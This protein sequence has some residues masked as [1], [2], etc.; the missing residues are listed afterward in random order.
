MPETFG[1][2]LVVWT[3]W[4]NYSLGKKK[5]ATPTRHPGYLIFPEYKCITRLQFQKS[6]EP[7]SMKYVFPP[8]TKGNRWEIQTHNMFGA[9]L[10]TETGPW[11]IITR[12]HRSRNQSKARLIRKKVRDEYFITYI[13]HCSEQSEHFWWSYFY[14]EAKFWANDCYNTLACFRLWWVRWSLIVECMAVGTEYCCK[15]ET[16][17][18]F[19]PYIA[20]SDQ[21]LGDS[22]EL[23]HFIHRW[24][25]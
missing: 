13:V 6:L 24:N 18:R 15:R 22:V 21:I 14:P 25:G 7:T 5:R 12:I 2:D 3:V 4:Y 11:L 17:R 8:K 1:S 10:K 19:Y 9:C 23:F 16:G 20:K